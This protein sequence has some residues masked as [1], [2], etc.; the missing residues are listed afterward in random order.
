[1]GT[2]KQRPTRLS[3]PRLIPSWIGVGLFW[4]IG[5]LPWNL[6]L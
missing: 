5:Q 2:R 6:L 4:L 1:M 3:D